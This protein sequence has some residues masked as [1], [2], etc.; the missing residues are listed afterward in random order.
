MNGSIDDERDANSL[1][2]ALSRD[3][4]SLSLDTYDLCCLAGLYLRADRAALASFDEELL[5]DLF[6]QVCEVVDPGTSQTRLRATHAVHRL[7]E[8]RMLARVDGGGLVRAG[9]YTLTRLAAAVVEFFLADEA[10]TRENLTLLTRTLLGQLAEIRASAKRAHTPEQWR[11][12]VTAPL[13]VTVGDLVAGIER[14]QRGLDAAQEQI[15]ADIARL[16]KADWFEAVDRAQELLDTTTEGLR[17][18]N[19]VLM[20]DASQFIALLQ[21]ILELAEAAADLEAQ[22]AVARVIEQVDRI[23][24]WGSTRQQAWS[25]YYQ[26]VHRYLRDVVRLD[27]DRALSQRLRD[28]LAAWPEAPFYLNVAD[29]P[30]LITVREVEPPIER[31]PVWRPARE[32]DV[33]PD[34]VDPELLPEDL[35]AIVRELLDAGITDVGELTSRV[36]ARLPEAQRFV[37]T[38]RVFAIVASIERLEAPHEPEW[39]QV[40]DELELERWTI[41]HHRD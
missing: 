39:V 8:Q 9:E 3:G 31:P 25:E 29:S 2:A 18:L 28:Q 5:M 40:G 35:E 20:R 27:P 23:A 33:T 41:S 1:I 10:L 15:Q 21:E 12:Q 16:L 14:R 19:E 37:A 7:R 13:G 32:R 17:E 26:Y 36:L 6:E 30:R 38:G 24:A 34:A 11:A 22:E 4:I